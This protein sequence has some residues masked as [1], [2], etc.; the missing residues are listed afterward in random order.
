MQSAAYYGFTNK[1]IIKVLRLFS[2]PA[3]EAGRNYELTNKKPLFGVQ[4]CQFEAKIIL[5]SCG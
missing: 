4:N 3:G 2:A 5:N 1:Q